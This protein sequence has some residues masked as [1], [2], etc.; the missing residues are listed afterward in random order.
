MANGKCSNC[1]VVLTEQFASPS[2]FKS[3][4]G[5]CKQCNKENVIKQR[6]ADPEKCKAS[7]RSSYAKKRKQRQEYRATY[8][9]EH[10]EEIDR[11]IDLYQR[12]SKGKHTRLRQILKREKID[13]SDLLWRRNFYIQ[14]IKD[15][16]CHYCGGPLSNKGINLDRV[17]NPLG[18]VCYNVVPCCSSCNQKKM[19]DTTY[20][21][22]RILAPALREIR[23]R[24][25]SKIGDL[26]GNFNSQRV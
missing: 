25:E 14:L 10:R 26:D 6:L 12:S 8:L 22:M 18:H 4:N 13:F 23:L 7:C 19:H 16:E 21:E 3:R 5:Y 11:N 9:I 17:D 1:G 15:N 24:R 20:E 2:V